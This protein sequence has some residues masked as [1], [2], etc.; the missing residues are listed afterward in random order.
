MRFYTALFLFVLT[1]SFAFAQKAP[2]V[3]G[4]WVAEKKAAETDAKL[5]TIEITFKAN[6]TF[7]F[8][9]FNTTGEGTYVVK[10]KTVLITATKRNG[11][12]PTSDMDKKATLTVSPDGKTLF[13][14]L[15]APNGKPDLRPLVLKK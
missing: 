3:V 5:K 11:V 10:D 8:K 1:L 4:T 6:G 7:T 13:I 2:K 14:N 9:G 15:G 12:K